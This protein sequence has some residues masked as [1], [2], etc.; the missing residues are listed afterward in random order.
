MGRCAPP[1]SATHCPQSTASRP[2]A[3]WNKPAFS[4]QR[5]IWRGQRFQYHG[6]FRTLLQHKLH[7]TH[8]PAAIDVLNQRASAWYEQHDLRRGRLPGQHCSPGDRAGAVDIDGAPH[9]LVTGDS[10]SFS[11]PIVGGASLRVPSSCQLRRRQLPRD[12]RPRRQHTQCAYISRNGC[13]AA[14]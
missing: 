11:N 4:L 1:L 13:A 8:E 9:A 3:C 14:A 7:K 6:L 10:T 2:C 5:S 12:C